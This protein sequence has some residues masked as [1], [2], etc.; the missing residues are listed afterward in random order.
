MTPLPPLANPVPGTGYVMPPDAA[1]NA[2]GIARESLE[3]APLRDRLREVRDAALAQL[4]AG[5]PVVDLGLLRLLV[6]ADAALRVLDALDA[7]AA[8]S[9]TQR[10]ALS[11]LQ[12]KE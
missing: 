5:L 4:A 3:M 7:E 9:V 12:I 1:Q 8:S 2:P 11:G 6:D 10:A